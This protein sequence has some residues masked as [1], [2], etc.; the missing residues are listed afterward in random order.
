MLILLYVMDSLRRD[1]L[2]CYGDAGAMTPHLDSFASAA[3][4]FTHA[5][6]A[7]PWSKP[8]GAALLTGYLPRALGMRSLLDTLP[9]DV[10][11]LPE[12]LAP[13]GFRSLAVSANPFVSHDFALL[14]GWQESVEAFRPGV[15]P[16]ERFH[17][18]ANQFHRAA[19]GLS[20]APEALVLARSS[21]LHAALLERL[22]PA[23]NVLALC[24]S[25]DTH[26]P[27]F[28][29]GE[30][31]LFGNPLDRVVPAADAE[32]LTGGLTVRDLLRLLRDMIAF[33]DAT[34]GEL[35]AA[36]RERGQWEGALVAVMG[37]HGEAFG[38]HGQMG[39]TTGLWEE[40]IAVPLLLKLP[41]QRTGQKC[42]TPVWLGDLLPTILAA[43][44][45][46]AAP[47]LPGGALP[48]QRVLAGEGRG[49]PL[50][51]E[52]P[53]GWALRLDEW[54]AL[55]ARD[56]EVPLVF[57]LRTDPAEQHPL[58]DAG[59]RRE[60]DARAADLRA[61]ADEQARAWAPRGAGAE[62]AVL[63]ARLRS[64]GYL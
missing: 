28:V 37:D 21:A 14:R 63:L 19:E 16:G 52:S 58:A 34:F 61:A 64:L 53:E 27:F 5:Y 39:H 9:A 1:L 33:N 2:G 48:L 62:D 13:E 12:R 50:L 31:S 57:N 24:W 8:S 6:A 26:A 17:F 60:M 18:H 15:L 54:K 51:M 41:G 35:V 38:E 45:G 59:L 43:L 47:V 25:M 3:T 11:T 22:P 20:V 30:R 40:Q 42:D 49:R 36:L 46:G 4:R 23:G 55:A 32:W 56:G 44:P 10:P 7:A 29:R